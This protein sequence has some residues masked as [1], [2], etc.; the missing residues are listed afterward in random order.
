MACCMMDDEHHTVHSF[1]FLRF[2]DPFD[3]TPWKELRG[4]CRLPMHNDKTCT[5]LLCCPQP[6]YLQA[7][8]LD[9]DLQHNMKFLT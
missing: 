5:Y 9:Q 1:A 4:D 7:A 2:S 8:V 6:E 3:T